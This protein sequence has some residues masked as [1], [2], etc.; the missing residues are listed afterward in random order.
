MICTHICDLAVREALFCFPG[1]LSLC[2]TIKMK[3]NEKDNFKEAP[4]T[5]SLIEA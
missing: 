2:L 3:Q 1:V 4:I 5:P